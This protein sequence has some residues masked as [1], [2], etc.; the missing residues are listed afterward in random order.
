MHYFRLISTYTTLSNFISHTG[1]ISSQSESESRSVL[2]NA[3]DYTVHGILQA[4]ILEWVVFPSLGD[5][6]NPETESRSPILQA[7]SLL[8]EPQ[9]KPTALT[10]ATLTFCS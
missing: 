4:R 3:T 5:L 9:G 7:D 10:S 8:A 6:P 1:A 2:C